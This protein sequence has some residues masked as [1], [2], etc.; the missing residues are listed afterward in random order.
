MALFLAQMYTCKP[1]L[2]V[3]FTGLISRC[4]P[5][6]QPSPLFPTCSLTTRLQSLSHI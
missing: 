6:C 4:I 3:S 2:S 5:C 1:G